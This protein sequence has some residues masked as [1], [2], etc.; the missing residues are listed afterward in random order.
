[1]EEAQVGW[2]RKEEAEWERKRA[3]EADFGKW[4][5]DVGIDLECGR[6]LGRSF[7]VLQLSAHGRSFQAQCAACNAKKWFKIQFGEGLNVADF[8]ARGLHDEWY[9]EAPSLPATLTV[10][11][12]ERSRRVSEKVK[13][14][15]WRRDKGRCTACGSNQ[16]LEYDHII[17]FSKGGSNTSRNIQLLCE[18]CNRQKSAHI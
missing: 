16:L 6:C 9:F 7:F 13:N 14:E 1:M 12:L 18:G 4:L 15:V 11:G 3:L 5:G 17:P 2:A 10:Q 8:E